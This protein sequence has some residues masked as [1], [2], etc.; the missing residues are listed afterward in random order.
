MAIPSLAYAQTEKSTVPQTECFSSYTR[1]N[2][3]PY[4]SSK[5]S[6]GDFRK[7]FVMEIM[8]LGGFYDSIP[9]FR[10]F[11]F[12][13]SDF[14]MEGSYGYTALVD[15]E[16]KEGKPALATAYT[17]CGYPFGYNAFVNEWHT[18]SCYEAMLWCEKELQR[19][20]LVSVSE[21]KSN[22]KVKRRKDAVY[23]NFDVTYYLKS[24]GFDA[25]LISGL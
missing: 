24:Y 20:Y 4:F 1:L 17:P 7:V 3:H 18:T 22:L 9:P 15:L 5:F 13:T 10:I 8:G 25:S 12:D 11:Y 14:S 16:K 2:N 21:V 6:K 19:G 23:E